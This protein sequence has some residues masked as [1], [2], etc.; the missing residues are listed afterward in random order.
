MHDLELQESQFGADEETPRQTGAPS[1]QEREHAK[2]D[3]VMIETAA[4]V[5]G[6]MDKTNTQQQP[7]FDTES[8]VE[9]SVGDA[10]AVVQPPI[11]DRLNDSESV[12]SGELGDP[13][14]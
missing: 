6:R 13:I 3:P 10:T 9:E 5:A 2:L 8:A 11:E 7:Q 12:P 14:E 1:E 4:A